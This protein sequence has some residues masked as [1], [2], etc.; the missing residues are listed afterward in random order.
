M[1]FRSPEAAAVPGRRAKDAVS[2]A[3]G[4]ALLFTPLAAVSQEVG[5]FAAP[6]F[7]QQLDAPVVYLDGM[8]DHPEPSI[9]IAERAIV[10]PTSNASGFRLP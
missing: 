7:E 1:S 9:W 8:G 3:A 10:E 2:L 4:L 5:G 6:A